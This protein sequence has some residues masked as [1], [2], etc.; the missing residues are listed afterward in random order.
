MSA[1]PGRPFT[2][3]RIERAAEQMRLV[4]AAQ[5]GCYISHKR[6]GETM[7][8]GTAGSRHVAAALRD[9]VTPPCFLLTVGMVAAFGLST[10]ETRI[11][12]RLCR[13]AGRPIQPDQFCRALR[14]V[15]P[16]GCAQL[17]RGH[18][19]NI[20]AKGVPVYT[21]RQPCSYA[22]DWPELVAAYQERKEAQRSE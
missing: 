9:V 2:A 3:V 17:L 15:E 21:E 1:H 20:R 22:V 8:L 5:G 7:Y 13:E 12:A 16:V 18:I 14:M 10:T 4:L 6:I 11:V 19:S